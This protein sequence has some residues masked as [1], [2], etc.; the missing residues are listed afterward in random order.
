MVIVGSSVGH[1]WHMYVY[2]V[3][4]YRAYIVCMYVCMYE[5]VLCIIRVYVC[6]YVYIDISWRARDAAIS[7]IY[8]FVDLC[9]CI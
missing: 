9:R 7:I 4:V 2:I 8:L 6:M 3:Y 5:C 1:S